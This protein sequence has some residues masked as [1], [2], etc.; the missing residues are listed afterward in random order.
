[1]KNTLNKICLAFVIFYIASIMPMLLNDDPT[2][3][4]TKNVIA[5]SGIQDL[6]AHSANISTIGPM[7][8]VTIQ[9]Q[10]TGTKHISAKYRSWFGM[11]PQMKCYSESASTV[12]S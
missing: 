10:K 4:V 2:A 1:M 11:S 5:L 8:T 9:Y 7:Q 6:Q 3:P 12:C